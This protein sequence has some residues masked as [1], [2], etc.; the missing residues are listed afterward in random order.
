MLPM[1]LLYFLSGLDFFI[2]YYVIGYRREVVIRNLSRSFP[3]KKYTEINQ[4][5]FAFYRAFADYF[6]EI[7]KLLSASNRELER[8]IRFRNIQVI[9]EYI[10]KKKHV[11]VA[12]GHCGNWELLNIIPL[13]LH[14]DV[15]A[16]YRPLR[17]KIADKL[18]IRMLSR[19]GAKM[20][21]SDLITRHFLDKENPPAVYFLLADQCPGVITN[22]NRYMFLNQ[23]TGMY[24][25][26]EK[27]AKKADCAV[28]FF[29]IIRKRRGD[30][31][32]ECIPIC[33]SARTDKVDII[34]AYIQLLENNIREEPQG[35]L[36]TH[37]QW[38]R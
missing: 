2:L 22:E 18:M 29:H 36:W 31:D 37:K 5:N 10:R 11:I 14:A 1:P 27:L 20:I 32:I 25:G 9:D 35:W 13:V 15:Y 23:D 28:V 24:K 12:L 4:I 6:V 17:N 3:E 30:Y 34:P 16:A 8:C 19:F 21:P 26:I 38:K 7:A 33:E